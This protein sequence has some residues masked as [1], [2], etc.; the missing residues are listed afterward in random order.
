VCEKERDREREREREREERG[1]AF[2]I[3]GYTYPP[4]TTPKIMM[5]KCHMFLKD[6]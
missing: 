1:R 6:I 4:V 3:S 5:V 2:L